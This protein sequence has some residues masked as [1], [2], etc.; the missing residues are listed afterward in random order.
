MKVGLIFLIALYIG[1]FIYLRFGWKN[2]Y[3]K[4]PIKNLITN[5]NSSPTLTD[6]FYLLYDK[7]YKDRHERIT[8]RYLK[9]FWTD[10]LMIKY[11]LQN[12]WQYE[13]TLDQPYEGHNISRYKIATMSLAFRINSEATP[14]KCFDYIMTDRY[15]K[16][17]KEF[18]IVDTSSYLHDREQVI[19]FIVANQNPTTWRIHP[20]KF[21]HEVDS[22]KNAL[23][24][25]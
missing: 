4:L 25:N 22:L 19:K 5:I 12:N 13:S 3:P 14:E 1:S 7:A 21:K 10:L 17:C 8:T 15:R 9:E 23:A 11:P 6:S 2:H 18:R 20:E 16:F 24:A